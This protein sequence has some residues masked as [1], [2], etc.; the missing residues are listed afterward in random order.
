[1]PS[2]PGSLTLDAALCLRCTIRTLPLD[3]AVAAVSYGSSA[4]RFLLRAKNEGRIELLRALGLQLAAVVRM[5]GMLVGIDA[6]V[7]VPSSLAAR[8]RR[9]YDPARVLALEMARTSCVPIWDGALRRRLWSGPDAK[10]QGAAE[11]W[12]RS[13]GRIVV[14]RD[15]TGARILLVD[16]VLTTGATASA[17]ALALR[18]AG[19]VGVRAAVW[20]RT[21]APPGAF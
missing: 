12:R 13:R 5:R 17:C 19:A 15:C 16:D 14:T 6:I 3:G 8:L 18:R 4:R 11:R 2:Q 7:P 10:E 20:A 21:P 9:G 1:M